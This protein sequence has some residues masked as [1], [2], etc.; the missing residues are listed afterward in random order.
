MMTERQMYEDLEDTVFSVDK[1]PETM[2]S[3]THMTD[4]KASVAMEQ[5]E[6]DE[7]RWCWRSKPDQRPHRFAGEE[8]EPGFTHALGEGRW[9]RDTHRFKGGNSKN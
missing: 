2:T 9:G 8:K 1:G 6:R 4:H 3:M 5:R 7:K